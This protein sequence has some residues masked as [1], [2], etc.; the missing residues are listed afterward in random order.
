VDR[1][2]NCQYFDRQAKGTGVGQCRRAAPALSPINAKSYMIEGVW[3][4]VRDDDWCGEWKASLRRPDVRAADILAASPLPMASPSR[5]PPLPGMP[6]A[7]SSMQP[8]QGPAAPLSP[9]PSLAI[10]SGRGND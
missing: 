9:L 3:P 10:G 5:F 1:C 7:T 4:T 6:S 2:S 8:T